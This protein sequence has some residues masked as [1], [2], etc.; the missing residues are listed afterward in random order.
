MNSVEEKIEQVFEE[1]H[2]EHLDRPFL[3]EL[4][5]RILKVLEKKIY[6]IF[7]D[8]Y[9]GY[10]VLVITNIEEKAKKILQDLYDKHPTIIGTSHSIISHYYGCYLGELDKPFDDDISNDLV[11]TKRI[12]IKKEKKE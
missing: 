2:N 12:I 10:E 8:Q 3:H 7:E 5:E 6:I 9:E 11:H 4:H 1:W